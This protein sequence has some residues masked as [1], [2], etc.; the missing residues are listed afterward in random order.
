MSFVPGQPCVRREVGWRR[1]V[2]LVV[3]AALWSVSGTLADEAGEP[4]DID[5]VRQAAGMDDV[6]PAMFPHWIHRMSYTCYACHDT[7]F[8]MKVGANVV[9][10]DL[11]QNGQ[12]CGVCHDGRTAFESSLTTCN[13]C[14]R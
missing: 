5:L 2:S 13:R 3:L 7:L 4:G 11:I 14:H 6:P 12:S 9:T 8:K 10:M 1:R